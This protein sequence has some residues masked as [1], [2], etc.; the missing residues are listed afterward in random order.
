L[1][2]LYSKKFGVWDI[3]MSNIFGRIVMFIKLVMFITQG[4][5]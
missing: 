1:K 4:D 5:V 2:T 3:P